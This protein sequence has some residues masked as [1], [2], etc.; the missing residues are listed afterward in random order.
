MPN[1]KAKLDGKLH[2]IHIIFKQQPVLIFISSFPK[3]V[4]DLPM[5]LVEPISN[6][7]IHLSRKRHGEQ[8]HTQKQHR[9]SAITEY[10]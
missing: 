6:I 2:R 5:P 7:F 9:R 8:E 4:L 10:P 1:Y 3:H